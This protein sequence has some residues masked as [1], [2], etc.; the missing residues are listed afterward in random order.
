MTSRLAFVV[1]R[2]LLTIPALFAMSVIV[3]LIV[4][5]VPGDPV[6]T[7]LGFRATAAN[8]EQVRRQLGLD[9]PLVTQYLDF[10]GGI[11]HGDLGTDIVSH[12]SLATLLAQRL[13]VTF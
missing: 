9:Q 12:E 4:R 5:L 11:L 7:M 8:V 10:V 3:F 2:V 1:R 6:R 13:P